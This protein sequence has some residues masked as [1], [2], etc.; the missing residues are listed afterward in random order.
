[1]AMIGISPAIGST[2]VGANRGDVVMVF[3]KNKVE[4]GV[5]SMD[6]Y[7]TLQFEVDWDISG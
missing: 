7:R 5:I 4:A 6:I 1:M 2:G 3:A